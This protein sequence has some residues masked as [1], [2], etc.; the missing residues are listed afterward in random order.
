MDKRSLITRNLNNM[1]IIN[2]FGRNIYIEDKLVGY[3]SDNALFV[4]G[5][6][7]ADITDYGEISIGENQVG[8]VEEDGS[9]IIHGKEVGYINDNNDFIFYKTIVNNL[10]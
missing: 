5:H 6:K 3:I 2:S 7:F 8:Y 10:K 4:S 1:L 9:I